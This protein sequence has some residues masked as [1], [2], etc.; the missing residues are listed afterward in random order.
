MDSFDF[1]FQPSIEK[2][3]INELATLGFVQRK[4]NL[5][6]GSAGQTTA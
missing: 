1:A 4:E 2:V 5:I 3:H 6:F